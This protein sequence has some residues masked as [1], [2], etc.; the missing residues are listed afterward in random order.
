MRTTLAVT[1]QP[2]GEPATVEMVKQ[3]CRIDNNAD[4][5]LLAGYL[6]TA[7]IMAEGYLSRALL[8]QT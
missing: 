8:T 4:D 5:D 2:A 1:T 7:R 3:H 6:T